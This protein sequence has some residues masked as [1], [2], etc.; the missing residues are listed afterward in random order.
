M[1]PNY[2][3]SLPARIRELELQRSRAVFGKEWT[4]ASEIAE[5]VAELKA[6]LHQA[7]KPN[8]RRMTEDEIAVG[9][10]RM[11]NRHPRFRGGA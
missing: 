1:I 10:M 6:E 11:W 8:T 3:K 9:E 7:I 4:K 2:Q 5:R